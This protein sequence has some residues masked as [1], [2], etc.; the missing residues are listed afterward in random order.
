MV[1]ALGRAKQLGFPLDTYNHVWALRNEIWI[2]CEAGQ[3]NHAKAVAGQMIEQ[4]ERHGFDYWQRFGALEQCAIDARLLLVSADRDPDVLSNHITTMTTIQDALRSIG[5]EA[6]RPLNDGL[7]GQLL[8]ASDRRDEAR[9]RLDTALSIT[10]DNEQGFYDAELLRLRAHTLSEPVARAAEFDAARDLA[11]RQGAPLFELR[12]ALDDFELRGSPARE[13]LRDAASR[14]A[15][16]S[17]L[18]EL[19]RT[20]VLLRR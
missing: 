2:R 8:I 6:Y 11:R 17:R 18:P 13:R 5:V 1:A 12:A 4:A 15:G 20:R 19:E 14:L 10:A 16:D 7:I 3:L 9:D